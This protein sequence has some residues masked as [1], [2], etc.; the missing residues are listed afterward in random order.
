V[1]HPE[2]FIKESFRVLQKDGVF[3]LHTQL[4]FDADEFS[5]NFLYNESKVKEIFIQNGF[6][7]ISEGVIVNDFDSMNYEFIF[8]K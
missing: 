6:K 4:G 7:I 1:L 8:I 5:V 2:K 3:I